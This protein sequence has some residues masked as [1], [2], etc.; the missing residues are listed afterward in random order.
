VE[1]ALHRFASR[2]QR[3][4]VHLGDTNAGKHGADDKRCMM[5]ARPSGHPPV[6]VTHQADTLP[7][8]ISGAAALLVIT[9]MVFPSG[10]TCKP[11]LVLALWAL[12][13]ACCWVLNICP[14]RT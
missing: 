1:Q 14:D 4:E 12:A 7:L 2:L 5:E 3:V 9:F 8:A 11:A 10:T 6:A 13:S